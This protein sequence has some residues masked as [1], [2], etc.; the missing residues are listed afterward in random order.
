MLSLVTLLILTTCLWC[1][2]SRKRISRLSGCDSPYGWFFLVASTLLENLFVL[3]LLAFITYTTLIINLQ[4]YNVEKTWHS[5]INKIKWKF[6]T[7][8]GKQ[9][10]TEKHRVSG[11]VCF[12]DNMYVILILH[13]QVV[14]S[15]ERLQCLSHRLA[16]S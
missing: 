10:Y 7:I 15:G 1:N 6:I 13:Q 4:Y 16:R 14:W 8:L 3:D 12:L 9:C 2:R 11:W 5:S